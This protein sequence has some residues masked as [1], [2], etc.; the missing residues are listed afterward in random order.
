MFITVY[1]YGIERP[2]S[3]SLRII[4]FSNIPCGYI[5]AFQLLDEDL[6]R[7]GQLATHTID[8]RTLPVVENG[9]TQTAG[10]KPIDGESHGC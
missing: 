2:F 4:P 7:V 6:I 1:V 8:S 3:R 9:V 10:A 5:A